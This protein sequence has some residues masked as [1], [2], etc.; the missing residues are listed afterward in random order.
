MSAIDRFM[1]INASGTSES[2][3]TPPEP[4]LSAIIVYLK[5]TAGQPVS[6][7]QPKRN[8]NKK[9]TLWPKNKPA[10][11]NVRADIDTILNGRKINDNESK[12]QAIQLLYC[13][14]N[15]IKNFKVDPI[16][17]LTK[18]DI[19]N[20]IKIIEQLYVITAS[21]SLFYFTPEQEVGVL[22]Y[23]IISPLHLQFHKIHRDGFAAEIFQLCKI[24]V[25][26]PNSFQH[27]FEFLR[28]L[29]KCTVFLEQLINHAQDRIQ[30][31]AD[32]S[33]PT[34]PQECL[35]V[36][37]K[38]CDKLRRDTNG[39][40]LARHKSNDFIPLALQRIQITLC[41]IHSEITREQ[42][43]DDLI[44]ATTRKEKYITLLDNTLDA[45][46]LLYDKIIK[47]A[48]ESIHQSLKTQQHTVDDE[49]A[50]LSDKIFIKE[51]ILEKWQDDDSTLI[52]PLIIT[53]QA[54]LLSMAFDIADIPHQTIQELEKLNQTL[55]NMFNISLQ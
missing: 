48:I 14:L 17:L 32:I 39:I 44:S 9:F 25:S 45:L 29:T 34:S 16:A 13:L 18:E 23:K 42:Q 46:A 26:A 52:V 24:R 55:E 43:P 2:S 21:K 19:N 51:F 27:C 37:E 8:K 11:E 31:I 30:K 22:F 49:I 10:K 47:Y 5:N 6:S 15:S 40:T 4:Q 41:H 1:V 50:N 54:E 53:K 35:M 33:C 36:D 20:N 38:L 12:A 3:L 7:P 28:L